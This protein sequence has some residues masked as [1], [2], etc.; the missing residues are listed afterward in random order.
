MGEGFYHMIIYN[1]EKM[2]QGVMRVFSSDSAWLGLE[3]IIPDII[4]DFKI[5]TQLALE[6][7]VDKGYSSSVLSN[8]FEKVIGVDTFQSDAHTGKRDS[9]QYEITKNNLKQFCNIE[10]V[11]SSFEEYISNNENHYNLVHIDIVHEYEPTFKCAEWAV[12][13]SN[14]TILH[15]TES[16]PAIKLVCQHVAARHNIKFYNYTQ[17]NGLGIL[18]KK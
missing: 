16:F 17:N 3:R 12:M 10:L 6:F 14:I 4:R 2:Y 15:D 7:G 9:E 1:P 5:P 13:H 11:K 8:F 18:V